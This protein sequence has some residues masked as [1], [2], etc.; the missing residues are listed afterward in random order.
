[1]IRFSPGVVLDA[2]LIYISYLKVFRRIGFKLNSPI[3][4]LEVSVISKHDL[5]INEEIRDREVRVISSDGEPVGIMSPTAALDLAYSKNLD[6]VK[7][8]P[9]AQPPVCK[10]MDYGKYVFDMAK[11][12]KEARKNQKIVDIKE[13]RLGL[14]IGE[15]DYQV[16]LKN[17]IKF[18]QGG[19]K[20]K[21]TVKFVGREMNFTKSGEELLQRFFNDVSEYGTAEKKPKMEGRRMNAVVS[22]K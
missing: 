14:G 22:P 7:I 6:L 18:L 4:F 12:E 15:H 3:L 8:A 19:D 16:K 17:A 21:V 5:M 2:R 1:M 13:V 20:V 9:N 10:I 11:K